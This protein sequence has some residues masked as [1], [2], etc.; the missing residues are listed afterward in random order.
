MRGSELLD[1]MELVDLQYIEEAETVVPGTKRHKALRVLIAAC[2]CLVV[3][4]LP[5]SAELRT[6][7]ISNLFAPLY[8]S[9][10]TEL[11][12]QIG[13]PVNASVE[14][15]DYILSAEAVIGDRY[16]LAMVYSL[17][18]A[19]GQVVPENLRFDTFGYLDSSHWGIGSG[20]SSGSYSPSQDHKTLYI[21]EKVTIRNPIFFLNRNVEIN[22]SD[23]YF[24]EGEEHRPYMDGQ[25]T[26]RFTLR[27]PDTS[28]V[29][30]A[31]K[32]PITTEEGHLYTIR[33]IILS[34]IGI[35]IDMTGPNGPVTWPPSPESTSMWTDFHVALELKDGS[36][37]DLKNRNLGGSGNMDS[38]VH[39]LYFGAAYPHPMSKDSIQAVY[40]CDQAIPIE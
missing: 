24:V 9:S 31:K 26:L 8:G 21:I 35:H 4:A 34:D 25:W 2:L 33:R 39:K 37:I 38:Q 22:F 40:I 7:Y 19:D 14:I 18:R 20:G 13:R 15:G 23:L 17:K 12:D 27:Y 3:L 30:N 10:Q 36:I 29:I 11:T 16:H 1:K 28:R 6:G 5:V 32:L